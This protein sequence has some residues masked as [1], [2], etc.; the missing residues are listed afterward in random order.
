MFITIFESTFISVRHTQREGDILHEIIPPHRVIIPPTPRN[1]LTNIPG[2]GV[3][4][5][6]LNC[7]SEGSKRLPKQYGLLLSSRMFPNC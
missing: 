2:T 1:C 4:N 3:G 5:L 6:P 7:W